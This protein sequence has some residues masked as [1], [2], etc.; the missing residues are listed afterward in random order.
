MS[1]EL[2]PGYKQ[3]EVGVIPE[4][5]TVEGL[6]AVCSMKSGEGITSAGIDQFSEYPCYGGN[7]LRGFTTRFTHDGCYSLIGRQ[8]A[9][10][11][12]V[13]GVK[14]RFF[15]SEHAIVVTASARTDIHWLTF[16]MGEMRL[17]QYSE[18]SAQPG[19]SVSKLLNLVVPVPPT[20]AEQRAIAEA[21]SD[22]DA[23]IESLEQL[24]A[25]KRGI[26]QGA[27]QELLTG[28]RR[29]PGFSGE[30]EVKRFGDV[31]APRHDRIDP[32]RTG[33]QEFC[34]ELEH[35]GSATGA[36]LGSSSTGG[37]SSLK[38]VFRAGDVL[39]GKLRAYLRKYWWA[40]CAGVCST[41]I[42][43]F[44][45]NENLISTAY[46]FQ[47]VQ[48]DKFIEVASSSYGTHMP[49]SDWNVVKNYELL[50]PP[51][52]EQTAIATILS[53]MDAEIAGLEG[54]LVKARQVKQGM[55]QELL[56]GRV[57]LV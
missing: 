37:Q 44:A 55:M 4:D 42:W 22:A 52:L 47:M 38:S 12:N 25:K 54:K 2:K 3:T 24:I 17:N 15:A 34:V 35:I 13:L 18:S 7:G 53:D 40:D 20:L 31:V 11:G 39:F 9:L 41:E 56:T 14:G 50:L 10:C 33:V 26:K 51:V 8:G 57:R 43:V 16:V 21:L 49:R 46:L 45:P 5:W 27:M 30:W 36:L 48:T 28:K 32:K 19:L 29:L 1:G 6:D 23:L